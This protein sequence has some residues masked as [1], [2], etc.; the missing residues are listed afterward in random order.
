[1]L[2]YFVYYVQMRLWSNEWW[3]TG[4]VHP[5]HAWARKTGMALIA[6]ALFGGGSLSAQ[7][8]DTTNSSLHTTLVD[9]W[10]ETTRW[11]SPWQEVMAEIWDERKYNNG[12]TFAVVLNDINGLLVW[13]GYAISM[14]DATNNISGNTAITITDPL[15]NIHT[16][17]FWELLEE[18]FP[19]DADMANNNQE[20]SI[21]EANALTRWGLLKLDPSLDKLLYPT[22]T[23]NT[24]TSAETADQ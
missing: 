9:N 16:T 2:F 22:A 20:I 8:I 24:P 12:E 7:T 15:G 14:S 5:P 23:D 21:E 6:L 4:T 19:F 1:M 11:K 13:S 18:S 3:S 10:W 17:T